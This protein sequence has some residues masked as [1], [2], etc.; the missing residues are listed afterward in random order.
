MKVTV[1]TNIYPNAKNPDSGPYVWEQVHSLEPR[2]RTTVVS[3][4][5]RSRFGFLPFAAKTIWTLIFTEY[6]IIHAH[7]GF[8]SAMLPLLFGWKPLVVTFHGS[9]ALHEPNRNRLYKFLQ[10]R[11]I[12]NAT[13][14]IAVSGVIKTELVN[15]L[16]ADP[17]KVCII[18]CG[19]DTQRFRFRP[20]REARKRLGL[21]SDIKLALFVGRLT[22]AKGVHLIQ[23]ASRSLPDVHFYLIGDGPI[24][25]H[26]ANCTFVGA[27][28]HSKIPEWFN[29]ADVFLLPTR[30]ES[31]PVIVMESLASEIPVIC[32][33]VGDCSE[34][35]LNNKTGILI[36]SGDA[37]ALMRAIERIFSGNGFEA[38]IGR[39]M[40]IQNYDLKIVAAKLHRL[41][42]DVINHELNMSL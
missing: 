29:A 9:D 40:V 39:Q 25:W 3:K 20:K 28:H 5:Q 4:S 16:G 31:I 13:K 36:P 27:L 7:Y 38:K 23:E 33:N 11:V 42:K 35:V 21:R 30:S 15:K 32:S 19:I 1:I 17:E 14:I 22:Y 37:Q 18:S 24:K 10:K 34:L 26:A 41:Y 2:V 6:D 12:A 8:H